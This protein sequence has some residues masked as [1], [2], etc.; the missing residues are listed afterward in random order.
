MRR[1]LKILRRFPDESVD[2]VVT[3]PPYWMLRDYRVK[4]QIGLELSIEEY[5]EKM[6]AVFTE[7]RRVLKPEGTCWVNL[8]DTYAN[9]S[10]G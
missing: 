1:S 8:G 7:V 2:C 6:L 9:L 5:L 4:G 3:S 10:S